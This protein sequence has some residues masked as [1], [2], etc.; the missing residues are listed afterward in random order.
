MA[1]AWLAENELVELDVIS[2]DDDA[3]G[4]PA[5]KTITVGG[6]ITGTG[7]LYLYIAGKRL[8]VLCETDSDTIAAAIVAAVTA[9][10]DLPVTA[11]AAAS[12]VTLTAK[13]DG[14]AGEEI[15]VRVNHLVGEALPGAIT[16]SIADGTTGSADPDIDDVFPYIAGIQYDVILHPYLDATNLNLLQTELEDRA[17]ALNGIPGVAFTGKMGTQTAL[18]TFGDGRN[19]KFECA[20]GMETFPGWYCTRAAAIAAQAA[21]FLQDDPVRPVTGRQ[22]LEGYAPAETDR[23]TPAERN[24]LLHD[25]ISTIRYGRDD[26]AEVERLITTYQETSGGTADESYLDIQTMFALSYTRK[27]YVAHFN[28]RFPNHKLADNGTPAPPGSAIVTPDIALADAVA[29]YQGLVDVG[30][31]ED[32]EGFKTNT[33]AQ[34]S[35]TDPNR[36]EMFL[37]CNYVNQLRVT[38]TMLQFRR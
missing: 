34:R 16:I 8:K 19:G 15:D 25:G 23:F 1:A 17:D 14:T 37:A 9:N 32:V 10:P 20:V 28:A 13:N 11:A 5:T 29:W 33:R 21:R 27:S 4:V 36:L 6:T 26:R 35:S 2:L 12:V 38:A 18:A 3:A 7:S 22:K 30:L 24:L 31:C